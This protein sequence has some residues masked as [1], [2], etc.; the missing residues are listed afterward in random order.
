MP[1]KLCLCPG[2]AMSAFVQ[3]LYARSTPFGAYGFMGAGGEGSGISTAPA[4]SYHQVYYV[5]VLCSFDRIYKC[6][7]HER[8]H[9]LVVCSFLVQHIAVWQRQIATC[10]AHKLV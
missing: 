6:Y 8:L 5:G 10:S 3:I 1:A 2:G 7:V 4:I 9:F